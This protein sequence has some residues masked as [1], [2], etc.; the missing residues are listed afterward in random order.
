MQNKIVARY[1]DG[2]V[3]K[4][5]TN[6]FVPNK[7]LF[8]PVPV[9]APSGSKPIEIRTRVLKAIFSE[10]CFVIAASAAQVSFL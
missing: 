8:H 1:Q 10:R 5:V 2:R 9:D 3:L 4:G 6:D 7:E